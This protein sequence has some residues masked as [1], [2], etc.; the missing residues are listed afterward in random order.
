MSGSPRTL[1]LVLSIAVTAIF[2][3]LVLSIAASL[4]DSAGSWDASDSLDRL[5][6]RIDPSSTTSS[7][8]ATTT[9]LSS[10]P[11]ITTTI[12]IADLEPGLS[13]LDFYVKGHTYPT[14]VAYWELEA[15]PDRMDADGNGVPCETVY[16][17]ADVRAH[18]RD[19]LSSQM[20]PTTD[21]D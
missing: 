18:F 4:V 14:V 10:R 8:P 13:C 3:V 1:A 6:V 9:S 20:P 5:S 11:T 19:P 2:A 21:S 17:A 7:L 12:P 16:P 15:N